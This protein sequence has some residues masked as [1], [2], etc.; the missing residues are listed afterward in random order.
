MT[1]EKKSTSTCLHKKYKCGK[2]ELYTCC[3]TDSSGYPRN[4]ETDVPI[5]NYCFNLH[6]FMSQINAR[7][8]INFPF[9]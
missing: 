2:K 9:S 3:I 1:F 4:P 8:F 5:T 6:H 7:F